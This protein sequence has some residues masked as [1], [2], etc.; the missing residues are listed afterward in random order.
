[1]ATISR[2]RE[3]TIWL[4]AD[5]RPAFAPSLVAKLYRARARHRVARQFTAVRMENGLSS[6]IRGYSEGF[7]LFLSYSA[8]EGLGSA[9]DHHIT[10]WTIIDHSLAET[11]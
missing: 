8:A 2:F 5:D 1:M 10:R 9:I 6:L 4:K 11:L 7:R 3:F